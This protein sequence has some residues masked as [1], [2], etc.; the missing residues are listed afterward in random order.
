[1]LSCGRRSLCKRQGVAVCRAT[2]FPQ[3]ETCDESLFSNYYR[4]LFLLPELLLEPREEDSPELLREEDEPELRFE[5]L[6]VVYWLCPSGLFTWPRIASLRV[7]ELSVVLPRLLLLD[8]PELRFE[9]LVVYWFCPW[10][11]FDWRDDSLERLSL[12]PLSLLFDSFITV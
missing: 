8:E 7:S 10:E 4:L 3:T 9:E 2:P 5:E 1:M 12:R 6:L 11:L